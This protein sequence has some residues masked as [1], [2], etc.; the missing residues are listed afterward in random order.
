MSELVQDIVQKYRLKAGERGINLAIETGDAA[1]MVYGDIGMLERVLENLIDNALRH[2]ADN[3]RV[4][5]TLNPQGDH[6]TVRVT[7]TGCGIPADK[8]KHVFDRFYRAGN[9]L[10]DNN[11]HAGLGL[12]IARR[13]VE[14]HGSHIEVSSEEG[15]GTEF[16]FSITAVAA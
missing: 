8:L 3:G 16:S 6:V 10:P 5:V 4:S 12:A 2:T 7:D 1:P 9:S 13:I 14:L 11:Q 15:K